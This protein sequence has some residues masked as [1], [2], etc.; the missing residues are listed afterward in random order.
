[1]ALRQRRGTKSKHPSYRLCTLFNS[2]ILLCIVTICIWTFIVKA[3][4]NVI[5]SSNESNILL[6]D[7]NLYH[8]HKNE[9]HSNNE[10]NKKPKEASSSSSLSSISNQNLWLNKVKDKINCIKRG[11]GDIFMY[12]MRKAAGTTL[13]ELLTIQSKKNNVLFLELEGLTLPPQ[14]LLSNNNDN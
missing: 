3:H 4:Q 9:S 12:H 8:S 11:Y 13:R 6:K 1:M 14:Y 5:I 7:S 10:L 2:L